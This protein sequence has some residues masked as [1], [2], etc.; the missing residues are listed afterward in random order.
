MYKRQRQISYQRHSYRSEAWT[1]V[2][3][4]GEV[5]LDGLVRQVRAG[6]VV[7]IE[8]GHMHAVRATSSDLHIIEVQHGDVLTEEDIERFGDFWK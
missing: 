3:G 4:E 6:C 2:A 8:V 7:N 5:V 1:V